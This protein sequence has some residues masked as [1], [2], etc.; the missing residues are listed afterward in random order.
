M[1]DRSLD[2]GESPPQD[3][4]YQRS[5]SLV[6]G[7]QEFGLLMVGR[8]LLEAP[9][10]AEGVPLAGYAIMPRVGL[11]FWKSSGCFEFSVVKKWLELEFWRGA[12]HDALLLRS[13]LRISQT[14]D[15]VGTRS[16][17]AM[18]PGSPSGARGGPRGG[19]R[20]PLGVAI[21]VRPRNL[22]TLRAVGDGVASEGSGGR[23][24]GTIGIHV[25]FFRSACNGTLWYAR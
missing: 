3:D 2:S 6:L 8:R 22:N 15:Y 10:D 12:Y 24:R 20:D 13:Q 9:W 25:R 17:G 23:S 11:S 16:I 4:L 18:V 21:L 19:A 5:V 1:H 7:L 14:K